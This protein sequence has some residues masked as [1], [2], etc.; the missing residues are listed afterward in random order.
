M[1]EMRR[2][3]LWLLLGLLL[4]LALREP[5]LVILEAGEAVEE[6]ECYSGPMR[7]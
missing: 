1:A 4:G 6:E 7:S 3:A 5:T 2:A